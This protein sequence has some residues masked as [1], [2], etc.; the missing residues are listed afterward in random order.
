MR[1][2]M[3]TAREEDARE[4]GETSLFARIANFTSLV[5]LARVHHLL[6]SLYF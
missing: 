6:R 2:A 4:E 1:R 5:S 3:P